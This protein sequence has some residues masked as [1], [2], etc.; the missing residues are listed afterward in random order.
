MFTGFSLFYNNT[1][2]AKQ[3]VSSTRR[4]CFTVGK[5]SD[6]HRSQA[7]SSCSH[8]R[9]RICRHSPYALIFLREYAGTH[10]MLSLRRFTSSLV[11]GWRI[12]A[13][14]Q[15]RSANAC[16]WIGVCAEWS[17]PCTLVTSFRAYSRSP[18]RSTM[19]FSLF[20]HALSFDLT[21]V[22]CGSLCRPRY[23]EVMPC[24]KTGAITV[25]TPELYF[26]SSHPQRVRIYES[27]WFDVDSTI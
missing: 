1:G 4:Q 7:S 12:D 26:A 15:P 3:L 18:V 16:C 9:W 27:E 10:L 19:L 22:R 14:I 5:P 20:T 6:L 8:T 17:P 11:W 13:S 2:Q 23:R 25:C 24:R 21:I